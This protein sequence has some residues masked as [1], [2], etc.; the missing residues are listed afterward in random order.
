[1]NYSIRIHWVVMPFILVFAGCAASSTKMGDPEL[2]PRVY[3]NEFTTVFDHAVKALQCLEWEVKN[4]NPDKGEIVASTPMSLLSWG[5]NF[6]IQL[7]RTGN[8]GIKVDVL[9]KAKL[10]VV[11]W[12]KNK[13][14]ILDFYNALDSVEKSGSGSCPAK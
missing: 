12:G 9:S 6:T 11:A 3:Q 7:S 1:M 2:E 14:N 13:D 10:Q 5:E 4:Q 8:K